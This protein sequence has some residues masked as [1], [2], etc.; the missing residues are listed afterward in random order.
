MSGEGG[1]DTERRGGVSWVLAPLVVF[2][3][4][5]AVFAF[6]LY[7]GDPSRLPSTL[8]GKPAPVYAFPAL[9]GVVLAQRG[10]REQGRGGGG[11]MKGFTEKHLKDG[12]VTLVN[13]WASWCTPCADEHPYL[14]ALAQ[15]EGVRIFGVNYKDPA[16][17]GR[18]FLSKLG[19]PYVRIG[20]DFSGRGAIEWGVYGMPE[21]FVVDGGGRVIFKHTGPMDGRVLQDSVLPAIREARKKA[22]TQ[23]NAQ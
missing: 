12:A 11:A 3:V 22:K 23:A 8:I 16:P 21:T 18:T 10:Q 15:R 20:T 17:G 9:D 7:G 6:A 2:S 14:M 1:R 19:N 4:M 5:A 13:F